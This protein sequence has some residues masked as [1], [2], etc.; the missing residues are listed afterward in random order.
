MDPRTFK[1]YLSIFNFDSGSNIFS[2]A[3]IKEL[4]LYNSK[5]NKI[6][7][8]YFPAFFSSEKILNINDE[9]ILSVD[10]VHKK[11]RFKLLK[12]KR[13]NKLRNEYRELKKPKLWIIKSYLL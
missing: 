5:N 7:D 11:S 9:K 13:L 4:V 8:M 10:I 2:F 12:N 6:T 1:Y 3:S